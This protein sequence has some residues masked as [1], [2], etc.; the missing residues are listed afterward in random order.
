MAADSRVHVYT[1]GGARPNPGPGGWGVVLLR[2]GAEAR[3]LSGGDDHTTN[4]RME[5]TAA[6]H[7]LEALAAGEAAVVHTD[8]QYLRRGITEWLPGWI[9]RGWRRKTG[10]VEN[11]DLWRRLAS[12]EHDREVEWKW[13][14]GHAGDRWNERADEIASAE[15][16]RH[17]GRGEEGGAGEDPGADWEI[18]LR[19]SCSGSRGGWAAAVRRRGEEWSEETRSGRESPTTANRLD[20]TA[21]AQLLESLPKG[22]AVAVYSGSDYLR[23]GASRWI[24]GW[25]KRRWTTKAGKAVANR[26]AWERLEAA[27]KR[28]GR[29]SW[30]DPGE[31]AEEVFKALDKRAAEVRAGE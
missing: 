23:L 17:G 10:K 4:N 27:Q 25:K 9:A 22:A 20:V 14:R 18:F 3:E 19:V 13:V 2:P 26:D 16:R 8:S 5:L 24:H 15:V 7:A 6:I 29:V 12:L 11:E 30:P 28:L 1:D 31:T 21:A